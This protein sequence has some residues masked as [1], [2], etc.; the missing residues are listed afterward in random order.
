M[1]PGGT[2]PVTSRSVVLWNTHVW[3]RELEVEF[4]KFLHLAYPGAPDVW[5]VLDAK[6]PHVEDLTRRYEHCRVMDPEE[7]FRELP[8]PRMEG[9]GILHHSHFPVLDFYLSHPDYEYYWFIEFDVRYTG[10]WGSFLRSFEPY[11]QDLITSHVRR[12][13]QEPAWPWWDSLRHPAKTIE[14]DKYLRSYNVIFRISNRAL[15]FIDREQRDGWEGFN[16]VS[17]PTLLHHGGYRVMDFGGDGDFAP[18]ELRNRTYTSHGLKN[19]LLC[20]FCTLSWRPSRDAPGR[21]AGRLYHSVKPPAMIE[22]QRE[23]LRYLYTW[24]RHLVRD[25]LP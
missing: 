21:R 8:Y 4:E 22:P 5:L 9:L 12:F 15:A 3:C 6:I 10:S 7:L 25:H 17:L 18:A 23:R 20:P 14:R 11:T 16:E 19:G 1:V 13:R 2:G 24:G